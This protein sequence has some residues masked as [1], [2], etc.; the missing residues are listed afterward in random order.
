VGPG[1]Q[2]S[3]NTPLHLDDD[4]VVRAKLLDQNFGGHLRFDP[5][6]AGENVYSS[7]AVLRPG[8][9][10]EVGLRDDDHSANSLGAEAVKRI[11]Q[12]FGATVDRGGPEQFPES[13]EI[14]KE[15]PIAVLEFQQQMPA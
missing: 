4:V 10:E 12:D 5:G 13:V 9:D 2:R 7:I 15:I 3:E 11:A 8:V 1:C 14:V 6:A